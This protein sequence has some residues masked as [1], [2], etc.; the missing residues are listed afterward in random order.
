MRVPDLA[1]SAPAVRSCNS[2]RA[3]MTACEYAN[4][5]EAMTPPTTIRIMTISNAEPRSSDSG[6][7]MRVS[8]SS[9]TTPPRRV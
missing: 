5:P 3:R 6:R 7:F 8:R 9:R 1:A 2:G 4:S